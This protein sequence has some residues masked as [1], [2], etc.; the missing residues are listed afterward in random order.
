MAGSVVYAAS[1]AVSCILGGSAT[2]SAT[3]ATRP[4]AASI[5]PSSCATIFSA[6]SR[7]PDSATYSVFTAVRESICARDLPGR[8]LAWSMRGPFGLCFD[9]LDFSRRFGLLDEQ[10]ANASFVFDSYFETLGLSARN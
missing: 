6:P 1:C 8:C 9:S 7:V 10:Q 4:P 2:Y 3:S 5:S